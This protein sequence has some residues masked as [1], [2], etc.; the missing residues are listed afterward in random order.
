MGEDTKNGHQLHGQGTGLA[1]LSK[2]TGSGASE[3]DAKEKACEGSFQKTATCTRN[4][5]PPWESSA[6]KW[7][8]VS[9]KTGVP[10]QA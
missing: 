1:E 4:H 8:K 6:E 3:E 2:R 9:K 10:S 5:V 7:I